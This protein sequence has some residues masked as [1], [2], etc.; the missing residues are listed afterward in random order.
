LRISRSVAPLSLWI[1]IA[2]IKEEARDPPITSSSE[3]RP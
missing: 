2:S 1:S 3:R